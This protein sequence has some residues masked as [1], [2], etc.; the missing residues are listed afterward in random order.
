MICEGDY[1]VD[2]AN[3]KILADESVFLHN[4]LNFMR[5]VAAIMVIVSHSFP[6]C[7]GVEY[8]DLV[9]RMT[10]GMINLGGIAV[11]VFFVT[12]GFL[13]ARSCENKKRAFPFFKARI[14]RIFPSLAVVVLL[15]VFV[16]GPVA[17]SVS[18]KEYFS[19]K[20]TYRYFLNIFLIPIHTLPGVFENHVYPSVVNGA[21]WTL[22]VEFVCYIGCFCAYKLG[23]F[24]KK[25]F[26]YTIPVAFVATISLFYLFGDNI[27]LLRIIRPILLY[28]IGIGFYV[29][30]TKIRLDYKWGLLSV[31][32]FIG[33]IFFNI[34]NIGMLFFFPYMIYFFAYGLKGKLCE[35]GRKYEISYG[36][37][38]YGWPVQQTLIELGGMFC[39][40]YFNAIVTVMIVMLLG[41][42]NTLIVEKQ[43]WKKKEKE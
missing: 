25:R 36:M 2:M 18:L 30:R 10:N 17:S 8:E 27:V 38:L 31:F 20:E 39:I 41:F 15:C 26:A 34:P 12:G 35:F 37:Y 1:K 32:L 16:L 5:F 29:Y 9:G 42:L 4:N 19:A 13:I 28:Y 33:T 40:C 21:L 43:I 11:G 23:F 6:V 24:D 3:K 14:R 7:Y 22:P